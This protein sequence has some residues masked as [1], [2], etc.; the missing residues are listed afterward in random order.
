MN[1]YIDTHVSTPPGRC[2]CDVVGIK[3]RKKS[4]KL[5][6]KEGFLGE[7]QEKFHDFHLALLSINPFS[8]ITIILIDNYPDTPM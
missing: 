3:S 4:A 8:S 6:I 7:I 1:T 2:V 5:G